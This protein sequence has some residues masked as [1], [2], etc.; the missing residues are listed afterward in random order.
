MKNLSPQ[1]RD[2]AEAVGTKRRSELGSKFFERLTI[3]S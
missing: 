3:M 2:V 1:N